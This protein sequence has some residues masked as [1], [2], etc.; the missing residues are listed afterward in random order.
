[1]Q[2]TK[3]RW[4]VDYSNSAKKSKKALPSKIRALMDTLAKEIE[5]G[6]PRRANWPNYRAFCKTSAEK[7]KTGS[8]V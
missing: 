3:P 5:L 6:G 1:M 8:L 4:S 7:A 2:E